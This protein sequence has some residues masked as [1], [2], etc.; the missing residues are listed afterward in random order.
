[1]GLDVEERLLADLLRRTVSGETSLD[2]QLLERAGRRPAAGHAGVG[3]V[4]PG[5]GGE[6]REEGLL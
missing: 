4:L 3:G 2:L 5:A 6:A 1:M